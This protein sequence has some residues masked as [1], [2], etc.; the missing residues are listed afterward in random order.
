[1]G[2]NNTLTACVYCSGRL[3][4]LG[5]GMVKCA[6]CR[7]KFSPRRVEKIQGLAAAFANDETAAEAA[8][9]LG[10]SYVSVHRL[11]STFRQLCARISEEQYEALRD[12][13]CEYEE[14]FY[15]ERSKRAKKN[16]VFDAHNF[17]TF[18]YEG[19]LYTIVMPSLTQYRQ[20]FIDDDL[21]AVYAAEFTRFKRQSR[22]IRI[23][24]RH[25]SIVRFWEYFEQNILRY[26]GVGRENFPLY[27]KEMEFK[28][29][30]TLDE[31]TALLTT[32][33]YRMKA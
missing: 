11:F 5:E 27:L 21:E 23:S 17:L 28:F 13:P 25:N 20:Q 8:E 15:L 3:Y 1:M 24:K 22:L 18:D 26:K 31:R 4:A 29:N 32:Y 9:R 33:Y 12:R 16:A 30:H 7:R 14:Y 6:R 2:P 19:H 10:F